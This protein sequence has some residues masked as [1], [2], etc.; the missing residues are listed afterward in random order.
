MK[1]VI[2]PSDSTVS[3]NGRTIGGL[4]LTWMVGVHAVV[5]NGASGEVQMVD[6]DGRITANVPI[7]SI[8]DYQGALDAWQ[9]AASILDAPVVVQPEPATTGSA[10]AE[11]DSRAGQITRDVVGDLAEEYRHAESEAKDW[12]AAGYAGDAPD[13]VASWAV[14][15]AQSDRQACDGIIALALA[16]RAALAQIRAARLRCKAVAVSDPAAAL[17]QWGEAE[18]EIRAQLGIS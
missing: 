7:E 12:A 15:S 10:Q 3:V 16:W 6:R 4:D 17:A 2:I 13:S 5:W 9:A 18:T 1:V 8:E 11:I 14:V